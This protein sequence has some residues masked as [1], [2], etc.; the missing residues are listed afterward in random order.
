MGL[1][2]L[3]LQTWDP[4]AS[5]RLPSTRASAMGEP[6]PSG[7]EEK[8]GGLPPALGRTGWQLPGRTVPPMPGGR[9]L[10][11]PWRL[12]LQSHLVRACH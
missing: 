10:L 7:R 9:P 8:F 2:Q 5:Q 11:Q 6:Y 3:R 1:A 4:W 12:G